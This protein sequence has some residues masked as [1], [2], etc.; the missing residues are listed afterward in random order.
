MGPYWGW[1]HW[2]T[3]SFVSSGG[4]PMGLTTVKTWPLPSRRRRPIETQARVGGRS[5]TARAMELW[6]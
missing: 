3:S 5:Q 2:N 1:L 6:W 4:Q